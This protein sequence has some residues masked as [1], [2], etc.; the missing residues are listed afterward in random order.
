M[1]PYIETLNSNVKSP[2]GEWTQNLGR[3]TLILGPN[4]SHKTTIIQAAEL[5]TTGAVDDL[6][7]RDGVKEAAKLMSLKPSGEDTL[8]SRA[9]FS[10]GSVSSWQG[11]PGSKPKTANLEPNLIVSRIARKTLSGTTEKLHDAMVE[12]LDLEDVTTSA[13]T[14][15][16]SSSCRDHYEEVAGNLR[17]R[18][19]SEMRVLTM[20]LEYAGKKQRELLS[21]SKA[22]KQVMTHY[23]NSGVDGSVGMEEIV[24]V[25]GKLPFSLPQTMLLQSVMRNAV[26]K[27]YDQCP[28]C[29]SEVG[30][31]HLSACRDHFDGFG[32]SDLQPLVLELQGLFRSHE[33]WESFLESKRL[34]EDCKTEEQRYKILKKACQEALSRLVERAMGSF[35]V[36][37]NRYLPQDW[38]LGYDKS[39][40]V[41]GL[42]AGPGHVFSSMSGAEW[43]TVT[44]AM[45]CVIG[46]RLPAGQPQLLVIE[47]RAWDPSTLRDVMMA[48]REFPGQVLMQGTLKPRG[49]MPKDWTVVS[50]VEIMQQ[51]V[52]S[53]VYPI[54]KVSAFER[55]MLQ[56][57]GFDDAA[58]DR[59]SP[60]SAHE[61]VAQ[62]ALA[63]NVEITDDGGWSL[64]EGGNLHLFGR[65]D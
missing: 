56:A 14:Q 33:R 37:V 43:A 27:D 36:D 2:R 63:A 31:K 22:H 16:M 30:L 6:M 20:V 29:G 24:A 10:D 40:G 48:L 11:E 18:F 7:G 3:Y 39:L 25:M 35:C 28:S 44:A 53:T 41:L 47:D 1:R 59:L 17:K 46:N 34:Y 12:L 65:D 5:A 8:Y 54:P 57:L 42:Q 4:R 32:E 21:E 52:A 61:I 23:K 19:G 64:Q 60:R 58:I 51:F 9:T 38:S 45:G 55:E 50:S 15:E 26:D 49:K 62:G 13:I